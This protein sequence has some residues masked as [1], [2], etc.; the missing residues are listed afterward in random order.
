MTHSKFL[1]IAR[2]VNE[3]LDILQSYVDF[4]LYLEDCNYSSPS[5]EIFVNEE[6]KYI[7]LN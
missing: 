7:E 6:E 2:T 4:D 3:L 1:G 5:V